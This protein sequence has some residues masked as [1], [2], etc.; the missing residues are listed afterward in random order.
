MRRSLPLRAE[1]TVR[2]TEAILAR[3]ERALADRGVTAE[4]R[5]P[6]RLHFKMPPV[7]RAPQAGVLHAVTSGDALVSAG[8]G[9]ARRVRYDLSFAGLRVSVF[10][11]TG[12]L[13]V[14]GWEWARFTL[15][16]SVVAL[17][18]LAF[19]APYALATR[20]FRRIVFDAARDVVE[21]RQVPRESTPTD[22][23]AL[24]GDRAA[25]VPR[26]E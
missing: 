26:P 4:R 9:E 19:G 16:N 24:P 5:G 22:S 23:A 15:F 11:L 20:R 1:P 21:R 25:D 18:L 12:L 13:L 2:Q 14:L 8:A 7:W 10:V 17:W 3:V 6:G